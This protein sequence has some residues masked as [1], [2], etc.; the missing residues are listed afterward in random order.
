[1]ELFFVVGN[2]LKRISAGIVVLL[3][4]GLIKAKGHN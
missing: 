2:V 3:K 4:F 1:M